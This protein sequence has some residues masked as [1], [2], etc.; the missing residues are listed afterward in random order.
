MSEFK[1]ES[2]VPIPEGLGGTG[3]AFKYPWRGMKIG[4]SFFVPGGNRASLSACA[5]RFR[6]FNKEFKFVA[7]NEQ[8]GVRVWRVPVKRQA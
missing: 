6:S 4:D 5:S 8:D 2:G 1:I 7:A 3:R